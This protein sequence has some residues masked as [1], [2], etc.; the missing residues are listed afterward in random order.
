MRRSGKRALGQRHAAAVLYRRL[1]HRAAAA[2]RVVRHRVG[3]VLPHRRHRRVTG[4]RELRARGV[5][6]AVDAPGLEL[7]V[8]RSGKRASRQSQLVAVV[9]RRA[10]HRAAAAVC[11]V[12]HRVG[13]PLPESDRH[14]IRGNQIDG[15][16]GVIILAV[17]LPVG[18][19]LSLRRSK[20]TLGQRR[21]RI[22][23]ALRLH[24]AAAAVRIVCNGIGG[25]LPERHRHRIRRDH[26][27]GRTGFILFSAYLPVRE[28]LARGRSEAG[29]G[30]RRVRFAV[31]K[32]V[33]RSAA[34]VGVERQAAVAQSDARYAA[35][36]PGFFQRG[37]VGKG[38]H[39]YALNA[40]F[41]L[42]IIK[43]A[44]PGEG[45]FPDAPYASR[46]PNAPERGAVKKRAGPDARHRAGYL[47]AL[48][49]RAAVKSVV[50]DTGYAVLDDHRFDLVARSIPRCARCVFKI[51]HRPRAVDGQLAGIVQRPCKVVAALAA[52]K[53][54]NG[55]GRY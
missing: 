9:H 52:A 8:R 12:R 31:Q 45:P 32:A 2:V 51:P 27:D 29:I 50:S 48:H 24:R 14:R 15:R 18:K 36:K 16:T 41:Y 43:R 7:L 4:R 35:R 49:R 55:I 46:D 42:Q 40:V 13:D 26:I 30:Q 22:C 20:L 38:A 54:N 33:H 53:F 25:V 47:R 44:A 39:P 11:A 6:R 23:E 3:D 5:L 1:F 10:V 21:V 17:D 28:H 19:D 37:A 34:A